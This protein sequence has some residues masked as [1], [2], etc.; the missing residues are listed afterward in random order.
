[1]SQVALTSKDVDQAYDWC[2]DITRREAKNFYYAF[3]T[4]PPAKRRAI[5]AAYAFGRLCDDAVDE[6]DP[7]PRKLELLGDLRRQLEAAFSIGSLAPLRGSSDDS[8]SGEDL[9][10]VFQALAHS[11][12]TYGIDQE[13]FQDIITG[14]ECDL[15]ATRYRDFEELRTYCYRVASVVGLICIEIFGYTDPRAR[16]YAIDL[17]LA[18]QLTN[19]IRDV[20]E[21]LGRGRVYLPQ[22]DFERFGYPEER[23][24]AGE[25]DDS[26][27]ELMRFQVERARSYFRSGLRLLPLLSPRARPCPAVMARIYMRILDRA[28]EADYNVFDGRPSL[29]KREKLFVMGRVWM[30]TMLPSRLSSSQP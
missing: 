18:M 1:M 21:D 9:G 14:V 12:A 29:S 19:I 2:R 27:R 6:D 3:I 11:S 5:Y 22:E 8:A 24:F 7:L 25:M 17:G 26:F 10:P 15:T 30:Q 23:L 28:E 4:L 13:L 20:E 16:Q